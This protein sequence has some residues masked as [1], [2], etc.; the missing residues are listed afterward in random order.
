MIPTRSPHWGEPWES[1][2]KAAKRYLKKTKGN[3]VLNYEKLATLFCDIEAFS[4][5]EPLIEASDDPNDDTVLSPAML[6]EGKEIRYLTVLPTIS[7]FNLTNEE[8]PERRW[9][10]M[11]RLI[12]QFW[13]RCSWEFLTTLQN[14]RKWNREGKTA[15][16]VGDIVFG[17]QRLSILV[18]DPGEPLAATFD[19]EILHP[20]P[21]IF[22]D[23]LAEFTVLSVYFS[24]LRFSSGSP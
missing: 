8:N 15:L 21:N 7:P 5:Q 12:S 16:E 2:I 22:A 20:S 9:R 23:F 14:R 6:V 4:T 24:R 3:N 17:P 11:K 10:F 1:G 19:T 13:K 18:W